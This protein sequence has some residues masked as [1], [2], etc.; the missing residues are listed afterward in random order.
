ML[1][2]ISA[3]FFVALASAIIWF[4]YRTYVK[5]GEAYQQ[6]AAPVAGV[7]T[8]DRKAA[9]QPFR[10]RQFLQWVGEKL[11]QDPMSASILR[12][13]LMVAGYRSDSALPIF[14]GVR[15]LVT[16]GAVALAWSLVP[17]MNLPLVLKVGIVVLA[18]VLGHMLTN[19]GLDMLGEQYQEKL[20]LALPDAL[21][22]MVVAVEAGLGLDQ[23]IMKVSEELAPTHPELCRELSLVSLETRAGVKR[24]DA[25]RNMAERTMEPEI[26]KL[27]AVLVQTDRFGT[28]VADALRTHAEFMRVRRRQLAEEKA[29]KLGPKLTVVIFFTILPAIMIV[30]GGPAILQIYR[31]LIPAMSGQP[32]G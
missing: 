15:T 8:T 23:A 29:N 20:R 30:A 6:L 2:A 12:R 9:E 26:R 3:A 14:I 21:D 10:V 11:P 16:I 22:L 32:G 7:V 5:P 31:Q 17:V 27:V 1:L 25:L 18:G 19:L 13:Q 28:S 4:G 24:A